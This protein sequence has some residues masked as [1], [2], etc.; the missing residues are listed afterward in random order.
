MFCVMCLPNPLSSF[1]RT[2]YLTLWLSKERSCCFP[3]WRPINFE[4]KCP[5]HVH[6][7][8]PKTSHFRVVCATESNEVVTVVEVPPFSFLHDFPILIMRSNVNPALYMF[9]KTS[10]SVMYQLANRVIFAGPCQRQSSFL[11]CTALIFCIRAECILR[12]SWYFVYCQT[13]PSGYPDKNIS[14]PKASH[15]SDLR[16]CPPLRSIVRNLNRGF[17]RSSRCV[18]GHTSPMQTVVSLFVSSTSVH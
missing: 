10:Q 8:P 7:K 11:D 9:Q 1:D 5:A 13:T 12:C 2:R 18:E 16:A 4:S 15:S 3:S 14:K 6:A 17:R